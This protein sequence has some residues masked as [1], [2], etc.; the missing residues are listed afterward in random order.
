[1]IRN[2]FYIE[3]FLLCYLTAGEKL[4]GFLLSFPVIYL[5]SKYEWSWSEIVIGADKKLAKEM[6]IE[7]Q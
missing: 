1:M 3:W 5:F 6:L 4:N 7:G 2:N